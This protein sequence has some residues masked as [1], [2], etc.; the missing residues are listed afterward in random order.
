M[1]GKLGGVLVGGEGEADGWGTSVGWCSVVVGI[2]ER[3]RKQEGM[4]TK[5]KECSLFTMRGRDVCILCMLTKG[6]RREI[7]G[8]GDFDFDCGSV[9]AHSA[10]PISKSQFP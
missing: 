3:G 4:G 2:L 1:G 5:S 6:E 8:V 7:L 9:S 10:L